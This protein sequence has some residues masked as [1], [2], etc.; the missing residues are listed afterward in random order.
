MPLAHCLWGGGE[1][2]L[3][4]VVMCVCERECVCVC[5]TCARGPTCLCVSV[6]RCPCAVDGTLKIE[7]LTL[8]RA[9]SF[10]IMVHLTF[11][12]FH[13]SPSVTSPATLATGP[14]HGTCLLS[15]PRGITINQNG[16]A[17]PLIDPRQL[18]IV[19]KYSLSQPTDQHVH[20]WHGN[21]SSPSS[22]V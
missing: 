17:W 15:G 11:F 9:P 7:E 20:A 14:K 6:L 12:S 16:F 8:W 10:D 2:V 1:C 13:P 5:G 21:S 18:C 22:I 3:V 4:W 19:S